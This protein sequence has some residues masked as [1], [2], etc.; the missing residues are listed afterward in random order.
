MCLFLSLLVFLWTSFAQFLRDCPLFA[1]ARVTRFMFFMLILLCFLGVWVPLK[2]CVPACCVLLVPFLPLLIVLVAGFVCGFFLFYWCVACF[3]RAGELLVVF[4]SYLFY[5]WGL[6]C[7]WV[8]CVFCVCVYM[9]CAVLPVCV[10][11][12]SFRFHLCCCESVFASWPLPYPCQYPCS[13]NCLMN[14]VL[15]FGCP[16]CLLTDM[17]NPNVRK[18]SN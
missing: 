4:F 14:L 17:I 3:T 7:W 18:W 11:C 8:C 12:K 9:F 5:G 10:E 2:F 1:L 13:C 15:L 6:V 16:I